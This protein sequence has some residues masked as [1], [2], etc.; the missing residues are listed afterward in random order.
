[1]KKNIK[2]SLL[3]RHLQSTSIVLCYLAFVFSAAGSSCVRAGE[4]ERLNFLQFFK[5]RVS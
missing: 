4:S 1:M 2:E 5:K 3:I